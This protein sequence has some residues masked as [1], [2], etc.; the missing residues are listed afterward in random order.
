MPFEPFHER[1]PKI[2]EK[3]TRLVTVFESQDSN[4]PAAEYSFIEMFCN[5]PGCDCRRVFYSVVSS[6]DFNVKAVIAWGWEDR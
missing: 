3:E 2:A 5:E 1:F 6:V 4:L